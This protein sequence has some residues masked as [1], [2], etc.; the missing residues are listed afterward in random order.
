MHR[1]RQSQITDLSALL[2]LATANHKFIRTPVV[3]IFLGCQVL[4][5]K[6]GKLLIEMSSQNMTRNCRIN[7]PI[8]QENVK[9]VRQPSLSSAAVGITPVCVLESS[10]SA[11]KFWR[12]ALMV[13]VLADILT[14]GSHYERARY[15]TLSQDYF[16]HA[17]KTFRS[18]C[19][20]CSATQHESV[21]F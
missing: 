19:S 18:I 2:L 12:L 3:L 1:P 13:S 6:N 9:S 14:K 10:V 4:P 7:T 8:S 5:T 21:L 15:S 17:S 16:V 11:R 20:R